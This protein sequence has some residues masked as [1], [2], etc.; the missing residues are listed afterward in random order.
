MKQNKW[1]HLKFERYVF[2][3][4]LAIELIM[5]FT[6]LGFLHIEPISITTAYIPI[7]V[8]GCLLGPVESTLIAM[9][10]GLS[11]M[12]KASA[13]YVVSVDR[14]FSPVH[15]GNPVGSILV[16]VG[17]RVLFGLVIGILFSFIKGRK[18]EKAGIWILSLIAPWMHAFFV[19]TAIGIYF[20][21]L[22]YGG[23]STL[24]IGSNDVI[25]A[26]FCVFWVEIA[27][28]IYHSERIQKY[29]DA[30]NQSADNPY[31]SPKV[32]GISVMISILV[33]SMAFLSTGYFSDRAEYML[34]Q[35][36]IQVTDVIE[37]DLLHLQIQFL[38]AMLALDFILILTMLM[39]YR[40]M[41][42]REYQGKIDVLTGVMGRR[43]FLHHCENMQ[44]DPWMSGR[45][46]W[47]LFLDVD[48]FKK[49]NDNLGHVV[50]D[51][52][53]KQFAIFLKKQFEEC[54]AVGRVGGDEFAVMIEREMSQEELERR[55]E[56]FLMDIS[57]ILTEMTV[58]C[59]I[60]AWHFEF[61]KQMK[62]LLTRTD[63]VL[64]EAKANG[65]ACFV[66]K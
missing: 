35:H 48:W 13:L 2:G 57:K 37:S 66:I 42:Y 45:Q 7:V 30:V 53:L 17:S 19:Y 63:E 14:I 11:S 5:A 28:T 4:L 36:K 40:Y 12:Y 6:F 8:A 32:I 34:L 47:F 56:K 38:V 27:Y 21:K 55:L 9:V 50:G 59:S 52:T 60:G 15:S 39:I 65:R 31:L 24:H 18:Y 22:G 64:Y 3:L 43:L 54:G 44:N 16:S 25:I 58:S 33:I 51:E 46:G 20:P 41:K 29:K 62:E 61:P 23:S 1:K 10:F 26:V 49:I